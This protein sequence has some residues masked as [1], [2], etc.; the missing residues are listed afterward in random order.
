MPRHWELRSASYSSR[1]AQRSPFS[2][3][4]DGACRGASVMLMTGGVP[5][6]KPGC[7]CC[8]H[9]GT[10]PKSGKRTRRKE[11]SQRV[12]PLPS[13]A[14]CC[15]LTWRGDAYEAQVKGRRK[16][17]FFG[18]RLRR[19]PQPLRPDG[20]DLQA[21]QGAALFLALSR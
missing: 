16:T 17:R 7:C 3:Q 5:S 1:G 10:E 6:A 15:A 9:P 13:I 21:R 2:W 18:G 20:A 4:G 19:L 12:R 14:R 11:P 8:S